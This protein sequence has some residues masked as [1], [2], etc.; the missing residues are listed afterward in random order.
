[1][2]GVYIEAYLDDF[3]DGPVMD[4]CQS[5]ET[6]ALCVLL[7]K[8]LLTE[9]SS[10]LQVHSPPPEKVETSCHQNQ[11]GAQNPFFCILCAYL[12]AAHSFLSSFTFFEHLF[13]L[14][15]FLKARVAI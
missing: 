5:S 12:S 9:G 6:T 11:V 13:R 4:I 15:S 1:M 7:T 14:P 3:H 10:I 8:S 2:V